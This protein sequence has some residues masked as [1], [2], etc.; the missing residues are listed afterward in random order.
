MR[1]LLV[2]SSRKFYHRCICE[3]GRAILEF[4]QVRILIQEW[5]ISKGLFSIARDRA[6]F[7]NLSHISGQTCRILVKT[8]LQMYLCTRKSPLDHG[9]QPQL[10]KSPGYGL[11]LRS[12][13]VLVEVCVLRVLACCYCFFLQIYRGLRE[14]SVSIWH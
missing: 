13:F 7:H 2:R 5:G 1:N 14:R 10:D 9:I 12:G 4:I 11:Q 8:L 3:G 6:F